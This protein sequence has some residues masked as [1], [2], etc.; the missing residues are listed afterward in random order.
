MRQS[1]DGTQ[2]S[3]LRVVLAPWDQVLPRILGGL[4]RP[5]GGRNTR[6]KELLVPAAPLCDLR[7]GCALSGCPFLI[8]FAGSAMKEVE[9]LASFEATL[10]SSWPFPG[11][12]ARD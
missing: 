8:S 11:I 9:A 5:E 2:G 7:Q 4:R 1:E 10:F 3:G 12:L 6:R